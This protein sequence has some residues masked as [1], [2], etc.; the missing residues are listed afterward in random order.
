MTHMGN[1]SA[2]T[3]GRS[4]F[5]RNTVRSEGIGNGAT[6][7]VKKGIVRRNESWMMAQSKVGKGFVSLFV[8]WPKMGSVLVTCQSLDQELRNFTLLK[9]LSVH[10]V[11]HPQ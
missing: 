5:F 7:T 10:F 2:W 9:E 6:C 1:S 11:F 4:T 3:T 8:S